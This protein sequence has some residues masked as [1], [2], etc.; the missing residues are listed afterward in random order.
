MNKKET[1]IRCLARLDELSATNGLIMDFLVAED[2][3]LR[4]Q[5]KAILASSDVAKALQA[6]IAAFKGNKLQLLEYEWT[7]LP[8]ERIKITLITDRNSKEFTW[9]C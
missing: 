3:M 1:E 2:L 4:E 6:H 7:L 9:N 5:R 8:E